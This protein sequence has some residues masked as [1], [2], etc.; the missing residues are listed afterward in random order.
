VLFALPF[1]LF[2]ATDIGIDRCIV[3]STCI[4]IDMCIDICIAICIDIGVGI[5]VGIGID[6]CIYI[7][8]YICI[9][10]RNYVNAV[11]VI[12]IVR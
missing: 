9:A 5:I 12:V 4:D 10:M 3:I 11:I 1:I 7:C 2:I 6:I 8:S